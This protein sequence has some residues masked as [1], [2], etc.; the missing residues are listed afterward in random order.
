M[1]DHVKLVRNKTEISMCTRL[2]SIKELMITLTKHA[3]LC[4][5]QS[6]IVYDIYENFLEIL[7]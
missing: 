7:K 5:E 2:D 6:S 1:D 3:V 4:N